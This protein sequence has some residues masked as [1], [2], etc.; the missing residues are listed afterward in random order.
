M[1]C[2]TMKKKDEVKGYENIE[3]YKHIPDHTWWH[4]EYLIDRDRI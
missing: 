3:S 1:D 2:K 4:N